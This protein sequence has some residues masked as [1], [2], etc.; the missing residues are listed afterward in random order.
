MSDTGTLSAVDVREIWPDEARDFTPWLA[1][2][3][4]LLGEVLGLD[5]LHVATEAKVGNYS[6]D[7]V[8]RDSNTDQAVVVENMFGRTDHDHLGKLV[9]YAAGLEA[10]YAVLIAT[11]F[12]DEHRSAL[13]CLNR[14]STEDLNLFG[15]VIEA[16]RIGDSLPAPRLRVEVKPKDWGRPVR[17]AQRSKPSKLEQT[18][19]RF[20]DEFIPA[21]RDRYPNWSRAKKTWTHRWFSFPSAQ[22]SLLRYRA[23]FCRLDGRPRLRAE[24]Y[25]DNE[26]EETAKDTFEA[27]CAQKEKIERAVGGALI[28]DRIDGRRASRVSLYLPDDI[29]VEEEDRWR[30]TIEW[31]LDALG[32]M[33]GAFNPAI[34]QVVAQRVIFEDT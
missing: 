6:A 26:G 28:W 31:L 13:T 32:R 15:L 23:S 17:D 5:L 20:W 33:R 25:I 18:Y 12:R 22:S 3:A 10:T 9:T 30:D 19:Q 11:E 2:R 34:E 14:V 29:R 27:L 1:E 24:A 4:D 16:W 7:I 21:L 8:F